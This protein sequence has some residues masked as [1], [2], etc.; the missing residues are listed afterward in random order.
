M[1]EARTSSPGTPER[2]KAYGG[3][4]RRNSIGNPTRLSSGE[5]ASHHYLRASTGSCHDFCKYGRKHEFEAKTRNPVPKRVPTTMTDSQNSV[6]KIVLPARKRSTVAKAKPSANHVRLLEQNTVK[7]I[8]QVATPRMAEYAGSETLPKNRRLSFPAKLDSP[9]KPKP[10]TLKLSSSAG[11]SNNKSGE[12]RTS[13]ESKTIRKAAIVQPIKKVL[14]TPTASLSPKTSLSRRASLN[15]R[16]HRSVK[17]VSTVRNHNRVMK[18]K[19]KKSDSDEVEG[20]RLASTATNNDSLMQAEDEQAEQRSQAEDV[21]VEE[22]TLHVIEMET[23]TNN[24]ESAQDEFK[25]SFPSVL[26]PSKASPESSSHPDTPSFSSQSHEYKEIK[27]D[28]VDGDEQEDQDESDYDITDSCGSIS[29]DDKTDSMDDGEILEVN[30]KNGHRKAGIAHSQSNDSAAVKLNFRRGKVVDLQSENNRPRRLRF[31]RG[32]MLGGNPNGNGDTRRTFKKTE[33]LDAGDE[34]AFSEKVVLRHQDLQGKKDAQGLFNNVIEETASKLAE[35]R[36]SK[37]KAL[38]GA[39]ETVI[40]LQENWPPFETYSVTDQVPLQDQ[41][42]LGFSQREISEASP[43]DVDQPTGSG[44]SYGSLSLLQSQAMEYAAS[45]DD[46]TKC[47]LQIG[48]DCKRAHESETNPSHGMDWTG[49][50]PIK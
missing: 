37:V 15:A 10:A 19:P 33:R 39:F 50:D 28:G 12:S 29:E 49:P 17:V 36:K 26:I 48:C 44:S 45:Q 46:T 42:F 4:S 32:R 43:E 47:K 3:N 8:K 34:E 22:K 16:K 9:L 41:D 2:R 35:T 30:Q 11:P 23:G 13:S 40:S 38:V 18:V 20:K 24:L 5:H 14:G 7:A 21:E 1:S 31:R 25:F 6:E 27:E